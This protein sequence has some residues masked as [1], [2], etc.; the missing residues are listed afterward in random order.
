MKV[1]CGSD[2]NTFWKHF[3]KLEDKKPSNVNY[4]APSSFY[5]HFKATF[6]S[7]RPLNIPPDSHEIGKLDH[8]FTTDELKKACGI[9]KNGKATGLDNIS[10]EMLRCLTD[11]Y[12][13]LTLKLFND[14]LTSNLAIP[15]WTVAMIAPIHKKGSKQDPDNYRGISLLSCLGK[16]FMAL[17]NNRLLKF[18]LDNR[19]ISSNQ[20]GFLPG[21]RTSDAHL[22]IL[23]NHTI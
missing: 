23:F 16:L 15:D 2:K 13:Q 4:V 18:A 3:K 8:P 10:N 11:S 12:P 7:R 6:N 5:N 22:I 14:I 1:E 9:L 20:L 19:I 21:N 17:L